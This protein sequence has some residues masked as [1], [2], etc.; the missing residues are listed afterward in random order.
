MKHLKY[1]ED[2]D[3][4]DPRFNPMNN[5]PDLIP[6]EDAERAERVKKIQKSKKKKKKKDDDYDLT[7]NEMKS[8]FFNGKFWQQKYK[9]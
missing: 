2:E 3:F 6:D 1:F 8:M 5:I 4:F 9:W 7:P